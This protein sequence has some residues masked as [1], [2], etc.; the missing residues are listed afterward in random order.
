MFKGDVVRF[1]NDPAV[2]FDADVL[3]NSSILGAENFVAWVKVRYIFA[4]SF[5]PAGKVRAESGVLWFAESAAQQ[6]HQDI[7]SHQMPIDW[8]K[9]GRSDSNQEFSVPRRRLFDVLKLKVIYTI[10][11]AN[12]GFH[13]ATRG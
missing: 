9:G 4:N 10:L 7:A 13:W 11:T 5:D 12:N 1:S 2:G 6:A 8:I 3:G